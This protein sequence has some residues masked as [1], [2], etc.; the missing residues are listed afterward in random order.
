MCW[1]AQL[2]GMQVPVSAMP[3]W[4]GTPPPPHVS[5]DGQLP[6]M[7]TLPQPSPAG[8]Q[9]MFWAAHVDGM[10]APLSG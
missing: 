7:M 8:P 3:H 6:H 5:G 10:H 9:P 2:M 4:L 1:L